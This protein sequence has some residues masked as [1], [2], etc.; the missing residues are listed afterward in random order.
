M[1]LVVGF[2]SVGVE[3]CMNSDSTCSVDSFIEVNV[4][5]C[6]RKTDSYVMA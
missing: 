2:G 3:N 6:L 5:R 4:D 1:V